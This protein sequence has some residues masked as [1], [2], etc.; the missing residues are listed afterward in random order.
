MQLNLRRTL[1]AVLVAGFSMMSFTAAAEIQFRIGTGGVAGVYFQIGASVCRFIKKTHNDHGLRCRTISTDGSV[2]NLQALREGTFDLAVV[3]SDLQHH[4][5]NGTSV[6]GSAGPNKELRA[7]FSVVPESFTVIAGEHAHVSTLEDLKGQKVNVGNPG[8]GQ[9]VAMGAVMQ[10]LGWTLE[11]FESAT[12]LESTDQAGQ[13]CRRKLDAAVYVVAHPNLSVRDATTSCT[14]I[15]VPVA[16]PEI[17]ELIA[18][19]RHFVKTSIPGNLYPANPD[20][21]PSFGVTATVVATSATSPDV[22]YQVVKAVFE[23]LE[24]FKT[25]LPVFA[26][27]T[28]EFMLSPHHAAPW[29][30]GALRYFQEAGMM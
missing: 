2:H 27:L 7:L 6:F 25:L 9:R 14:S 20:P 22:V 4:A 30:P 5:Y 8:S 24:E 23:N 11:D 3:Q 12:E 13:I 18:D 28:T 19:N 16:G 17:E 1:W 29:H 26:K 21:V 10:Y 15:L